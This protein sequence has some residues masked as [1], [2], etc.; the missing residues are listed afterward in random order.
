MSLFSRRNHV[1]DFHRPHRLG[2]NQPLKPETVTCLQNL[3]KYQRPKAKGRFPRTRSAAVLVALFI[4][5]EGDLYVLLS[6][7][8]D[9]LRSYPGDTSLPGGKRERAD[10]SVENAAR[11][12]AFE[13]IGL[14]F[15][16]TKVPLLCILEPFLSGNEMV[17][18]PVVVLILDQTLRP[19]LNR[20]EVH[21][22][23]SHPLKGFIT[24][25]PVRDPQPHSWQAEASNVNQEGLSSSLSPSH[26]SPISVTS[27]MSTYKLSPPKRP[28][29][30]FRDV[31]LYGTPVRMHSFLTGREDEGV[32]PVSGLTASILVR[33]ALIGYSQDPEFELDAPGQISLEERV[34]RALKENEKLKEACRAEGIDKDWGIPPDPKRKSTKDGNSKREAIRSRL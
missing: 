13:E 1:L 7:R 34:A 5:R 29:R 31:M 9:G 10:R 23:F 27:L 14:P 15:D 24:N 17:V 2:L 30:T 21:S 22:L 11:R 20:A 19:I 32:K 18:T 25:A 28:Y 8:S 12:E 6:R 4:G 26:P 3:A 16:K 33:V